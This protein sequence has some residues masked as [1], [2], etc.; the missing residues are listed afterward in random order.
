MATG[1]PSIEAEQCTVLGEPEPDGRL[2]LHCLLY[3]VFDLP[4]LSGDEE[5]LE[6]AGEIMA[7]AVSDAGA[8]FRRLAGTRLPD[9]R[10]TRGEIDRLNAD[11]TIMADRLANALSVLTDATWW[12]GQ[13]E[14][15]TGAEAYDIILR[16]GE[17]R[18]GR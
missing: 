6:R 8:A 9:G 13:R 10:A 2:A 4:G 7:L 17:A 3:E 15:L 18:L 1:R 16:E 5:D 11:F 12:I 14:R